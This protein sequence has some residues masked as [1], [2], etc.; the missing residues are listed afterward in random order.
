MWFCQSQQS[1][2]NHIQVACS[3]A[4]ST[5]YMV[6]LPQLRHPL[7]SVS[8][9]TDEGKMLLANTSNIKVI[10]MGRQNWTENIDAPVK[11]PYVHSQL[12]LRSLLGL[13]IRIFSKQALATRY[14]PDLEDARSTLPYLKLVHKSV[15]YLRP[16][17]CRWWLMLKA[18]WHLLQICLICPLLY[19]LASLNLLWWGQ[20]LALNFHDG[21][22][23]GCQK[24]CFLLR[25]KICKLLLVMS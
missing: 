6:T 23:S 9:L 22:G 17:S 15:W 13:L 20:D 21:S 18:A 19:E 1:S 5:L 11:F 3:P 4:T 12:E 10:L 16:E 2:S 7:T 8:Y 24:Y 14:L 25:H